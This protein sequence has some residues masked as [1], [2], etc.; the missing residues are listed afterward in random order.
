MKSVFSAV[1]IIIGLLLTGSVMAHA[2]QPAKD[3]VQGNLFPPEL[4][5]H[6]QEELGIDK[7]QLE[8]IQAEIKKAQE[9]VSS[10]EQKLKQAVQGLRAQLEKEEI[11][12]ASTLTQLDK[13]LDAERGL[14]RLHIGML[15][16]IRNHLTADQRAQA[17]KLMAKLPQ[18]MPPAQQAKIQQRLHAKVERVKQHVE[19]QAQSGN[20]PTD[21]VNRM[22]KF[23]V[24]MKQG[25]IKKAEALLDQVLK[26][27]DGGKK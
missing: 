13:V 8:A 20:P 18:A 21:I 10:R 27:I 6:H 5:M 9:E 19:A 14:K 1:C 24:L 25:K 15:V 2:E 22:Q 7:D 26:S 16:R 11:D 3:P 12:E 17:K 4:M 23:G